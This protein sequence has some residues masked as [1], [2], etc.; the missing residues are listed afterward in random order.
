M[1]YAPPFSLTDH[2]SYFSPR[3]RLSIGKSIITHAAGRGREVFSYVH[4]DRRVC[5]CVYKSMR[6]DNDFHFGLCVRGN[7]DGQIFVC[8]D[9]VYYFGLLLLNMTVYRPSKISRE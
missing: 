8:D 5:L 1:R 9:A 3:N 7:L 4:A 2:F 6:V